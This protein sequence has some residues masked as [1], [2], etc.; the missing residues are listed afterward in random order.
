MH[1][2]SEMSDRSQRFP[3]GTQCENL[4][5]SLIFAAAIAAL[6]GSGSAALAATGATAHATPRPAVA[7]VENASAFSFD[8]SVLRADVPVVVDFWAPW[9]IVCRELEAPLAELAAEFAGRARV[10]RVNIDWSSRVARRFDVT[11]LP[12]ILIFKG[13]ELV[14]RSSGAASKQDLEELLAAQLAPAVVAAV[15]PTVAAALPAGPTA[16]GA[17]AGGGR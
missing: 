10:V 13:G 16:A 6:A 8:R 3:S 7:K 4:K 9:C 14:S 1:E 12:T 15:A 17:G 2:E 5:R 11:A